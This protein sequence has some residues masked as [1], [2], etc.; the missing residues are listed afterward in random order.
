MAK[1][2]LDF[3]LK[4]A[5]FAGVMLLVAKYVPYDDLI[6]RFITENISFERA[7][8]IS[9]FILGEPDPEA[10]EAVRD[11]IFIVINILISVPLFS[12][13]VTGLNALR[14]KAKPSVH[15]QEWRLSV[16]RRLMKIFLFIFL[17]WA[18]LRILPYEY[19]FRE[20]EGAVTYLAL[21]VINLTI[22]VVA[23]RM[24]KKL[25]R[26]RLKDNENTCPRY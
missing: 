13:I 5:L 8:K 14:N 24:V 12:T 7:V 1:Y 6:D 4:F 11:Y 22:T 21:I 2:T 15:F 10:Y 20:P 16:L 9:G 3:A 19:L 25:L 26:G 23:Y 17:F 18:V